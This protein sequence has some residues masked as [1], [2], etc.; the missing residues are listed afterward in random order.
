MYEIILSIVCVACWCWTFGYIFFTKPKIEKKS[1]FF[2]IDVTWSGT[3]ADEVIENYKKATF[4]GEH[5]K[6]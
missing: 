4:K 2:N 3:D 6:Y 5:R 1:P